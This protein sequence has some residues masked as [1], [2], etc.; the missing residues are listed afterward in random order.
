M[1]KFSHRTWLAWAALGMLAAMCAIL[2]VLQYR[3]TGEIAGAERTRL[4]D[5]L[6]A[7]L[8]TFSRAF[9]QEVMAACQALFPSSDDLER[10]DRE[11]AYSAQ[12]VR[13]KETH[14]RMF[15]HLALAIPDGDSLRL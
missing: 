10:I 6:Q 5:E 8:N 3:W 11:K 15:R 9:N 1:G 7:R 2:A 12:Y 14:D 13:W 4:H